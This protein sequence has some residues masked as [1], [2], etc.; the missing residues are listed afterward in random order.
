[1]GFDVGEWTV[2]VLE[3]GLPTLP[4]RL[5]PGQ[6]VAVA[7]WR[8]EHYGAVL[9]VR[10]WKNRV[11]DSDC[12]ITERAADGSWEEPSS[13]GG[14]GW[15][16]DPLVRSQTGWDGDPVVWLGTRGMGFE[17]E[18][19][20]HRGDVLRDKTSPA[21]VAG[22]VVWTD[23]TG[24]LGPDEAAAL[25]ERLLFEEAPWS[26]L[27]VRALLGA[28]SAQVDAIEVEHGGRRWTVPIESPCGA[29]IVGLESPGRATLRALDRDGRPLPDADGATER[30]A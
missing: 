15:I 3:G 16:D 2:R 20:S 10:L 9:F 22:N 18:D 25:A 5:E 26:G 1:M 27:D 8:G 6:T 30:V 29:F 24:T 28:A 17:A 12:A 13:W 11:V 21:G 19:E 7:R 14:T 23:D 4:E